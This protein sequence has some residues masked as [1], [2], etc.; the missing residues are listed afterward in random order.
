[1]DAA[2][3]YAR[4]FTEIIP[5]RPTTIIHDVDDDDVCP[6]MRARTGCDETRRDFCAYNNIYILKNTFIHDVD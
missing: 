3:K 2:I 5:L 4:N 6:C 1:M